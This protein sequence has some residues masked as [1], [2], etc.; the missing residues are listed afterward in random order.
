MH[1]RKLSRLLIVSLFLIFISICIYPFSSYSQSQ[2]NFLWRLQAKNSTI[3]LLGSIH[4]LKQD[5][6]PLSRTIESAFDASD[7][8]AVEADIGDISRLNITQVLNKA[9]YQGGDS[10]EK[11]ISSDA[12]AVVRKE[13]ERLGL[14]FE[15]IKMQ[16]P[17]LLALTMESLELM[18]AGYDPEYGIDKHFLNKAQGKQKIL[19]LE[20]FDYQINLLSGFSDTEQELFLLYALKDLDLLTREVDKL[21][22]AWKTGNVRAM[23]TFVTKAVVDEN[24]FYPIYEKLIIVRNRNMADRI[25]NYLQSGGTYFVVV[26]AAHL[27]GSRG[28]IQLLRNKGYI[29]EQM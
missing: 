26:G 25:E 1:V 23:E 27:T 10:L 22:V 24:R 3:Y 18:K 13:A 2:K 9:I 15:L 4:L 8:L 20:S 19:E 14:P 6:Y 28:I 12:I 7:F 16:K 29:V 5:V 17:W 11:H 21:I